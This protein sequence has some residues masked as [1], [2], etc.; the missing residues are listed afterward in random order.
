MTR[1]LYLASSSKYRRELLTRLQINFRCESP[2]ID[3]SPKP[4]ETPLDTCKR[5]AREKAMAVALEHP[6]AIVIGSDQVADVGGTAISKPGTHDRARAQ[7]RSMSGKTI[8]F[9]TAVC[10]CCLETSQ[11][12]EFS[13]PTSV[14]FRELSTAEIERYLIA[15]EPYDCAGS[16]KSEGLGISLLKRIESSDPTAL[17]GLPL[18]EVANALRQFELT[19]P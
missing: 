18:I 17:I 5:L 14:E 13:V 7:L 8:V 16:A 6:S 19:L 12:V 9:H 3:E 1:S 2:Q 15:E 4:D 10:I 11:T